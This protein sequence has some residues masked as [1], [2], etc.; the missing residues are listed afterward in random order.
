[1]DC[2]HCG[3]QLKQKRFSSGVLESPSMLKRR[4]FCNRHCMA[5]AMT[6]VILN[7]NAKNSRRQSARK[8]GQCCKIC[9]GT[10]RLAVHHI[11][12]NPLNNA[13]SNLQTLCASCHMKQHW[14]E[15]KETTHRPK[16]C[17]HCSMPARHNGLCNSHYT[18]YRKYG[19]PLAVK[20]KRGTQWVLVTGAPLRRR[21]SPSTSATG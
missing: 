11:D 21:R 7:P 14:L 4:K 15:W 5:L 6:G 19:D 10:S 9:G 12:S 1:M 13:P 2:K 20:V 3:K 17:L 18:R 16:P 8:V